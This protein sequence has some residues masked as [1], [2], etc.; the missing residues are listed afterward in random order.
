MKILYRG[1]LW[2]NMIDHSPEK[3]HKPEKPLISDPEVVRVQSGFIDFRET[4]IVGKIIN[5]YMKDTH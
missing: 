5:Q 2:A 1:L 3:K 4:G